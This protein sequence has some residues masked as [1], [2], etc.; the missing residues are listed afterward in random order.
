MLA[1][2]LQNDN[3]RASLNDWERVLAGISPPQKDDVMETLLRMQLGKS[4]A[5]RDTMSYYNRLDIGHEGKRC[6]FLHTSVG[7]AAS[8]D[9]EIRPARRPRQV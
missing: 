6:N 1:A 7:N 8:S 5:L 3:L 9:D 2:R 4:A